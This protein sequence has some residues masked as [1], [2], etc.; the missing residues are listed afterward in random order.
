MP[1]QFVYFIVYSWQEFSFINSSLF[2]Y[3]YELYVSNINNKHFEVNC[4]HCQKFERTAE[5]VKSQAVEQ[6]CRADACL[7]DF[8][9][10]VPNFSIISKS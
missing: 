3:Q 5:N 2:K 9:W 8:S 1:M 4:E 7:W 6:Y 10:H